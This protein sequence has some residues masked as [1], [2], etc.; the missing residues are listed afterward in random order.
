[1]NIGEVSNG[2]G[3]STKLIRY[4]ESINLIRAAERTGSGYRVYGDVDVQTLRFIRR[5][6]TLGFSI[7]Q[8]ERLLALWQDRERAS[9]EVRAVALAHVADLE[10]KIVELR[11]M[12]DTLRHLAASC[13]NDSRPECPILRDLIEAEKSATSVKRRRDRPVAL[14]GR[15]STSL[16]S[17]FPAI[18]LTS[19][20]LDIRAANYPGRAEP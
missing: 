13:K 18:I 5:A 7:K 2:S 9:S 12:A 1:M 4:Y 16:E 20:D 15:T 17:D 8:I 11:D 10:A 3:V 19:G 14:A 6:R